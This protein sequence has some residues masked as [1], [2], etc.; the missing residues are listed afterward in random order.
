MRGQRAD[1]QHQDLGA[2][3][4]SQPPPQPP[5]SRHRRC[6]SGLGRLLAAA[7]TPSLNKGAAPVPQKCT[8]WAGTPMGGEHTAVKELMIVMLRQCHAAIKLSIVHNRAYC[9]NGGRE[10]IR[11]GSGLFKCPVQR[12]LV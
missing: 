8:A 9:T 11:R 4:G 7:A 3:P 12:V 1:S 5:H 6:C 10:G 2:G